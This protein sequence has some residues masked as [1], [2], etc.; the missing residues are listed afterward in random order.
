M[1]IEFGQ[2]ASAYME[3]QD[4]SQRKLAR[5]IH[6]RPSAISRILK[7]EIE[8]SSKDA[9]KWE[10]ALKISTDDKI[11][12]N[13]SFLGMTNARIEEIQGH[14]LRDLDNIRHAKRKLTI[15]GKTAIKY[16]Y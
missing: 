12:F 3:R 14:P 13:L 15:R 16:T 8:P 4:L 6:V 9:E 11:E 10:N 2:R 5:L 1:G 7:G